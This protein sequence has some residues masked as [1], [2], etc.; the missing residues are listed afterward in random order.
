MDTAIILT[1]EEL[2]M[3]PD[4]LLDELKRRMTDAAADLKFEEAAKYR[5]LI[6]KMEKSLKDETRNY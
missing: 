2:E 6:K 3:S 1:D 4:I 5:D